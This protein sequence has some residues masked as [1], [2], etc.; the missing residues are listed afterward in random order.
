LAEEVKNALTSSPGDKYERAK[1]AYEIGASIEDIAEHFQITRQ[2]MHDILKRRGCKFRSN[3]RFGEANHFHRGTKASDKAQN[4]LEAEIK[5]GRVVPPKKCQRCGDGG[6]FKD[7]RT[8]I[9][10]HH[11][12]YGKPLEVMWLCQPCHH[13]WH[14]EHTAKGAK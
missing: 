4:K 12:D 11:P 9:Q 13:K 3:L 1:T 14:K 2:A 6:I 5:A 7:G 8:K 10:A